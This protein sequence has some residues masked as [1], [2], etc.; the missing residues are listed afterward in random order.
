MVPLLH[1]YSYFFFSSKLKEYQ[2]F[3]TVY[4]TMP[5]E[6][7]NNWCPKKIISISIYNS[8][9]DA[10]IVLEGSDVNFLETNLRG[11]KTSHPIYI[12]KSRQDL[13]NVLNLCAH[14]F[15]CCVC[16]HWEIDILKRMKGKRF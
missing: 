7:K 11:E 14:V 12:K 13:I 3:T 4:Q 5:S 2:W 16:E 1:E 15:V 10:F 6:W 8:D 9:H